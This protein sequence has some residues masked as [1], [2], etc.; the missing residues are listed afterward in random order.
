MI[1][2]IKRILPSIF[3]DMFIQNITIHSHSTRQAN[4]IHVSDFNSRLSQ[5]TIRFTGTEVMEFHVF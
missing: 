2:H 3:D 5:Q 1:K 4:N